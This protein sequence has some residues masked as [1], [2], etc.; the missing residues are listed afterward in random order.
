MT[1]AA[2]LGS[3]ESYSLTIMIMSATIG[4]LNPT[5]IQS[6]PWQLP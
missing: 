6:W 2:T 4:E 5:S 3:S 1:L